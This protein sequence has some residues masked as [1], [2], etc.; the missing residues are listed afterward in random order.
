LTVYIKLKKSIKIRYV[1]TDE[2]KWHQIHQQIKIF[3]ELPIKYIRKEK[4]EKLTEK[5]NGEN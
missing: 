5:L 2:E 4:L 3:D 1:D